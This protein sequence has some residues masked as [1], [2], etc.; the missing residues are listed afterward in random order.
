MN[1]KLL[2]VV[3]IL[4]IFLSLLACISISAKKASASTIASSH[5]LGTFSAVSAS[6]GS[7]QFNFPRGIAVDEKGNVYVADT[8]NHRVQKFSH[9]G[10]SLTKWGSYGSGKSQ[11][12]NP[13]GIAVDSKGNVYVCDLGLGHFKSPQGV[14]GVEHERTGPFEQLGQGANGARKAKGHKP[15]TLTAQPLAITP[16]S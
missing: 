14:G 3:S 9:T 7:G 15:R 1:N 13:Q 6:T 4:S 8:N 16:C 10:R 2:L 12:N 5:S 11:F